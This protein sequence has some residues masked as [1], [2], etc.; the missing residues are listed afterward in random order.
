VDIDAV[1]FVVNETPCCVWGTDPRAV[2]AEF[3][4]F[5]QP[6]FFSYVADIHAADL[7]G[8]RCQFAS[9]ALG[10]A[11]SQGLETLFATLFASL[12]APN[13]VPGWLAKYR[14]EDLKALVTAIDH[15]PFRTRIPLSGS[16]WEAVV[17]GIHRQFVFADKEA[18]VAIQ[19]Q[20]VHLWRNFAS[21]FLDP[22]RSDQYNAIKHGV[23]SQPGGVRLQVGKPLPDGGPPPAG[24]FTNFGGSEFGSCFFAL[25]SLGPKYQYKLTRVARNWCPE[26]LAHRLHL[27]ARSLRNILTF[28]KVV[29]RVATSDDDV[30]G[31]P[32]PVDFERALRPITGLVSIRF[33]SVT[34]APEDVAD[35]TKEDILATYG[36]PASSTTAAGAG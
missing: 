3:L 14:Q 27:V 11:Y 2:N 34:I 23:R 13:C 18:E 35:V 29:N 16:T 32:E 22:L 31:W 26:T 10:A 21:D 5:I 1:P 19:K 8:P 7:T 25:E 24:E 30:F 28:L 20:V 12:Q 4:G 15:R 6:E 33:P 36:P 17:G 9:M